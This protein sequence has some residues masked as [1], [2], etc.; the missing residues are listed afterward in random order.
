[1]TFFTVYDPLDWRNREL[2]NTDWIYFTPDDHK[3]REAILAY[4]QALRDWP[5]TDSFPANRPE[6]GE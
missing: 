2:E 4:R 5:S 6:L 1:M 3:N